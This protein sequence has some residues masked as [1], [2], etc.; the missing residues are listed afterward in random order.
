MRLGSKYTLNVNLLRQ[1][2]SSTADVVAKSLGLSAR[3]LPL[4]VIT[5]IGKARSGKSTLL[6]RVFNTKFEVNDTVHHFFMLTRA[7]R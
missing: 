2:Y 3:Q 6:N 7:Y 5:V 4:F 1:N